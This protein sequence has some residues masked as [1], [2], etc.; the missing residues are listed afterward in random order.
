MSDKNKTEKYELTPEH[1]AELEPWSKKWIK[2]AMSTERMTDEDKTKCVGY[3]KEMYRSANLT[4]PKMVLFAPSP[5]A[6]CIIAGFGAAISELGNKSKYT[7]EEMAEIVIK[8]AS[9]SNT[10]ESDAKSKWYS[11]PYNVRAL[12]EQLGLGETGLTHVK[13]SRNMWNGGNQWSGYVSYLSFFRHIVKLNI[14][15]TKWD[16][17]EQLAILSGPRL[18]HEDF[19]VISDRPVKLTVDA[20]N[21]PHNSDGP[22]CEWSDGTKLFS[23]NG[24]RLPAYIIQNP[25]AIT[26][27]LINAEA[28]LEIRRIMI[29]KFGKGRY[30]KEANGTLV[31][32]DDWGKLYK[33]EIPND[34]PLMMVEVVNSTPEPDGTFK[35]YWIRVQPTAYGGLKTAQAAIASTFRKKDG[36]LL[37]E[38]PEDYVAQHES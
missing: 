9:S 2:N 24:V 32:E 19:T 34:E 15:Y 38:K 27:D 21:R 28:N 20:Q 5:F 18:L 33:K 17:Y 37:F 11:V 6:A 31:H 3:V 23:V 25:T 22:F 13:A 1:R 14:D 10:N 7:H 8:S 29:D 26:V 4:E 36:S 16:A 12:N 35:N 30:I